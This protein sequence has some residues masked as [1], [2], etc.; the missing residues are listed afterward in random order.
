MEVERDWANEWQQIGDRRMEQGLQALASIAHDLAR[1]HVR[2]GQGAWPED[3]PAHHRRLLASATSLRAEL[4]A[5]IDQGRGT[6]YAAR[7]A[8]LGSR[9]D[10]LIATPAMQPA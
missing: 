10:A 2:E 1:A 5:L 8:D 6:S 3:G 7:F 9:I 4:Q